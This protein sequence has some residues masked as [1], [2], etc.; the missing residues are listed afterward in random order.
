MVDR[1]FIVL[2][3]CLSTAGFAQTPS[4]APASSTS[5]TTRGTW[6]LGDGGWA[7]VNNLPAG[8][9][10]LALDPA[11]REIQ[12]VM[13]RRDYSASRKQLIDWLRAN[14]TSPQRDVALM[15]MARTLNARGERMR[16][17]YYC[18]ELLDTCADSPLYSQALQFQYEIADNYLKGTRD[19]FWG[20]RLIDRKDD[21]V[22]ML[23]RIQQR[24]PGSPVSEKA[25]LRTADHYWT[26]GDFDLAA[27][28]YDAFGNSFPRSPFANEV[29]LQEARAN[30]AQ[31]NGPRF[32]ATPL[33]NAREQLVQIGTQDPLFARQNDI[34]AL[35]SE[36]ERQLA[37]K[38]VISADF[39]K[40]TG[41]PDVRKHLLNRLVREFPGTPEAQNARAELGLTPSPNPQP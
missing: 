10:T 16:A 30:L 13:A 35:I 9:P 41:K 19:R 2:M 15:M 8:G 7:R 36:S 24:S 37:R 40:R 20:M 32:D 5:P 6:Q 1:R 18:D 29:K 26:S 27:D 14:P 38:L 39:Y 21:G 12:S 23:F 31:Y 22:E 25:L 4:V 11:L 17:F 34:E 3:L 28:A 33:I